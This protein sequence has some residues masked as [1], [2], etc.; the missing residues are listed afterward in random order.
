MIAQGLALAYQGN[1][2]GGGIVGIAGVN[3]AHLSGKGLQCLISLEL[4]FTTNKDGLDKTCLKCLGTSGGSFLVGSPHDG[5]TF[6]HIVLF[7]M[8]KQLVKILNGIH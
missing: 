5:N 3:K 1:C 4:F 8:S 6:L 7:K 2:L